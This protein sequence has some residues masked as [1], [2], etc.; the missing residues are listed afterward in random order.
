VDILW[1]NF[2]QEHEAVDYHEAFDVVGPSILDGFGE[3]VV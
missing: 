1:M 3:R 2:A